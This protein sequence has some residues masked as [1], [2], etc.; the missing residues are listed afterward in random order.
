MAENT[1]AMAAA[2][3][4][5][6]NPNPPEVK[7]CFCCGTNYDAPD[8][9]RFSILTTNGISRRICGACISHLWKVRGWSR[10]PKPIDSGRRYWTWLRR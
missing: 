9:A 7:T 2:M 10:N 4:A 8:K 3:A 5:K 1:D 6:I